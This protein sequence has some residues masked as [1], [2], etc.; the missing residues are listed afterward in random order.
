MEILKQQLDG[1]SLVPKIDCRFYDEHS[2][3]CVFGA[4]CE[5]NCEFPKE[6]GEKSGPV[7][8]EYLFVED[9]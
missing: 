5:N 7:S 6:V 4:S 8:S 1:S 2:E 3:Q 9:K